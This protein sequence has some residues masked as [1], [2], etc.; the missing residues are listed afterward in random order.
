MNNRTY[1]RFSYKDAALADAAATQ[2]GNWVKTAAHL[3]PALNRTMAI[4]GIRGVLL[5][6]D[7]RVGLVGRL[8]RLVRSGGSADRVTR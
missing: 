1:E 4:A 7:D 2:A 6:K 8:P 3:D 5:A